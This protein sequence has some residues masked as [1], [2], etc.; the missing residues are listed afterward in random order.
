[1]IEVSLA[2]AD[3]TALLALLRN[4]HLGSDARGRAAHRA[5]EALEAAHEARVETVQILGAHLAALED[6]R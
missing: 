3:L 2:H 5:F 6:R 4:Q 1:M